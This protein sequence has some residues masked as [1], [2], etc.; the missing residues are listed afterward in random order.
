MCRAAAPLALVPLL[1]APPADA[2]TDALIM[3]GTDMHNVDAAWLSLAVDDFIAPALGGSYIPIAVSTP[4]EFWPFGGI[5]DET[6][7]DSVAEGAVALTAAIADAAQ[8]HTAADDP[9]AGIVVFGYSQS[10]IIVSLEKRLLAEA[11]IQGQPTVALSFVVIG[12]PSRPNG[13]INARFDGL[14]LPGWTFSGPAPT[15]TGFPTVDIARQY[16]P[17]A[18]FPLYP[19]NPFALANAIAGLFYAHDYSKVS[20]DPADP[21]YN[22]DTVVQQFGDTTYYFI[23]A[24]HLPL[25]QPLRDIGVPAAVLDAIEPTLRMWVEAGYDR[26][27]PSGQPAPVRLFPAP[28]SHSGKQIA[29]RAERR[30]RATV[31]TTGNSRG[32]SASIRKHR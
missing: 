22:P 4:E 7:D 3:T 32:A 12:D 15:D 23:P 13:G 21:R 31:V 20:L 17:F 27:I 25:L 11:A 19:L 14:R 18:D 26:T 16:D 6:I 29:P 28:L 10:A 5:W 8:R 24:Q 1:L 30:H 9:G 2:L